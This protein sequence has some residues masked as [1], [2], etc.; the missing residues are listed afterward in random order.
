[1]QN[2]LGRSSGKLAVAGHITPFCPSG[3]LPAL[4]LAAGDPGT[5]QG[6]LDQIPAVVNLTHHC[7]WGSVNG[8]LLGRVAG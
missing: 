8:A 3:D 7:A 5:I 4:G 2:S 6:E 1:M